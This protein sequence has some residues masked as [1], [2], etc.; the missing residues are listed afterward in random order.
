MRSFLQRF[1]LFVFLSLVFVE[2]VSYGMLKTGLF[3]Y[4]YPGSEIYHAIAKSKTKTDSNVLLLGDSVGQQIFPN[5]SDS[6]EFTSLACN[7]A[8]GVI[9]QFFLLKNYLEAGNQIDTVVLFYTPGSFKSDLNHVYTYHYFL[10]PF[11]NEEYIGEF[12]EA[13]LEKIAN[14]PYTQFCQF[15]PIKITS[16]APNLDVDEVDSVSFLSQ[17]SVDYLRKMVA[18]SSDYEFEFFINPTP[19]S[20]DL[21]YSGTEIG[22]VKLS[23]PSDLRLFFD[24]YFEKVLYLNDDLFVDGIHLENP[25]DYRSYYIRVL[26]L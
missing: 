23:I 19:V 6:F 12:N 14:I 26:N 15:A 11:Y 24:E 21:M 13:S 2:L 4:M 8:I 3:L 25:D 20:K 22:K 1:M 5:E 18:L 7:Q 16:W 9:G 10:K 17:V